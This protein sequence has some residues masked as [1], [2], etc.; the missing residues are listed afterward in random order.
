V[1]RYAGIREIEN[2]SVEE[3][4]KYW[5]DKFERCIRCNACREVCPMCYCEECIADCAKPMKWNSKSVD[6]SNNAF[7][8]L[9]RA[10]HLVGR[11]IDCGE[12]ERVCPMDIPLRNLYRK[13][14]KEVKKLYGYEAGLNSEDAP[15]F[16]TFSV[17]DPDEFEK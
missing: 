5:E 4:K 11:C 3:R 6:V 13:L 16:A 10:M 2:M 1:D 8:H 17:D 15:L 9:M 12:C 7:Y 14:E